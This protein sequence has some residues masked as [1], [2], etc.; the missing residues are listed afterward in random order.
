MLFT[1]T[2]AKHLGAIGTPDSLSQCRKLISKASEKAILGKNK[3]FVVLG[4]PVRA[5]LGLRC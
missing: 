3:R 2:E 5:D 1:F 4:L